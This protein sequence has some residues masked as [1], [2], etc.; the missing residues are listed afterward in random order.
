MAPASNEHAGRG[1]LAPVTPGPLDDADA[2]DPRRADLRE[3][4]GEHPHPSG[5]EL[6]DAGLVAP[7]WPAPW[8]RGADV[9]YQLIVDDELARAGV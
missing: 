7:H 6:A 2:D 4:L 3:W 8:V 5:A 1:L 9:T